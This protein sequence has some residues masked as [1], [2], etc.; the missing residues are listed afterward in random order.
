MPSF[1]Q[2]PNSGDI[3]ELTPTDVAFGGDAVARHPGGMAVFIPFAL[4]DE[5]VK[6]RITKVAKRF[7]RAE[8][9]EVVT[10]S[11]FRRPPLC[12]LYGQC[13]GC[14]Y[15]HV[16]DRHEAQFKSSQ[17][18][19][20]LSRIGGITPPTP[21]VIE[22]S[23]KPFAYR[24]KIVL[25]GPGQAHYL[26]LD[27]ATPVP[28]THCPL[29]EPA[30]NQAL[31]TYQERYL[32][33]DLCLRCDVN[34]QVIDFP[35]SKPPEGITLREHI[36]GIS[37]AIP[38][39]AFFQVNRAGAE[40]LTRLMR[41]WIRE[42][43]PELLI[44]AY[45]GVGL[46]SLCCAPRKDLPIRGMEVHSGAIQAARVN[47]REAGF[48]RANF[49]AGTAEKLLPSTLARANPRTSLVLLDPPRSGCSSFVLDTLKKHRPM[50]L[51][52]I[53][54]NP[55]ALARDLKNLCASGYEIRNVQGV[56]L[57]P[58]TAHFEAVAQLSLR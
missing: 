46:F 49:Q 27:N 22:S 16:E 6:I 41:T 13:G 55:P 7:A 1:N 31:A 47:A 5:R 29:A 8:L 45:C 33:E 15:Q 44:D 20:V 40:K 39:G 4:P 56:N 50:H 42:I 26:A 52:Y 48:T 9:I 25:H 10:P 11:P 57:F 58:Q 18:Q 12:P 38:A 51:V 37:F 21:P 32:P 43:E 54:C 34:G 14:C 3:L 2:N 53:S 28:V 36:G 23:D 19:A 24:N 17:L 35:M 30:I